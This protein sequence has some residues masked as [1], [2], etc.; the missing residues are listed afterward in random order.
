MLNLRARTTSPAA[1]GAWSL[2][3]GLVLWFAPNSMVT[4][5]R[6]ITCD[7]LSPGLRGAAELSAF[8]NSSWGKWKRELAGELQ[9]DLVEAELRAD[10]AEDRFQR[11][12]G[13]YLVQAEQHRSQIDPAQKLAGAAPLFL[14]ALCDARIVGAQLGQQWRAGR[15]LDRGWTN[16]VREAALV[17]RSRR[18]LIDIGQSEQISAEDALVIGSSVLGKIE[19]VGRWTSTFLPVTD[20]DY[21]AAVQVVRLGE[22]GPVWGPRGILRGATDHCVIDG[23]AESASVRAGDVVYAADRDGTFAA[24][25]YFGEVTAAQLAPEAR[26]WEV[27]VKPSV[28][29]DNVTEVRVLRAALNPQR[30]WTH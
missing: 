30:L 3:A 19:V 13:Q 5:I 14:P 27:T 7:L 20:P 21:R 25:L 16:G 8:I 2:L 15:L 11:L 17:I 9:R 24:P 18:P 10:R 12:V 6:G 4:E 26:E 23:L 29:Q 28:S 22:E 1:L